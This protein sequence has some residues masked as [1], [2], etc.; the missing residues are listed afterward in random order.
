MAENSCWFVSGLWY[1]EY[2]NAE[3]AFYDGKNYFDIKLLLSE[4]LQKALNGDGKFKTIWEAVE[5]ENDLKDLTYFYMAKRKFHSGCVGEK[6]AQDCLD[7][8]RENKD[9]KI[10]QI[11]EIYN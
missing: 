11:G 10:H 3:Q 1:I 5:T 9:R 7:Y 2:M 4:A 6:L 8:I